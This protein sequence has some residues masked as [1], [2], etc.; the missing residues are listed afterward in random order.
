M[1]YNFKNFST[2]VYLNG[3]WRTRTDISFDKVFLERKG[4]GELGRK[5]E[6]R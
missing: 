5:M 6:R 3:S 2:A 4:D 1:C